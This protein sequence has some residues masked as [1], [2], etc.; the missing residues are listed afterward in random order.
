MISP[1]P[2]I[3]WVFGIFVVLTFVVGIYCILVSSD[4]I[5]ALIG[6]EIITKAVT[7]LLITAGYIGGFAELAQSFAIILIIVEVIIIT[8]AGGIVITFFRKNGT[9]SINFLK[10]LKG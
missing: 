10:N 3:F 2:P 8:V 5:R 9:I 6:L 7:L 4:L 1:L